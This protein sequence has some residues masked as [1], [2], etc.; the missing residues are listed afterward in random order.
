M[1]RVMAYLLVVKGANPKETIPL[2]NDRILLGRNANCDIVFPANDFAVSREHACIVRIQ[3]QFF[4]EDLGSRNG[5]YL[6]N[7]PIKTRTLLSDNDKVR[8]CDFQ[9]SFH[10]AVTTTP[11]AAAAP[12][13]YRA[14]A[15]I[16]ESS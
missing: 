8:I 12:D 15:T 1:E 14:E 11:A 6:N 2:E 5:T 7:Q 4:I 9:Y 10:N 3:N 13:D 16:D